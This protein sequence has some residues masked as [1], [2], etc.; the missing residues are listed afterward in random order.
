MKK[1]FLC[2]AALLTASL[3]SMAEARLFRSGKILSAKFMN[4][5]PGKFKNFGLEEPPKGAVYAAVMVELDNGRKIGIFDYSL[6]VDG[7]EY[8]C[9][10]IRDNSTGRFSELADGGSRRR[11]TL[12]FVLEASDADNAGQAFLVCK[13][14]GGG[15]NVELNFS[16]RQ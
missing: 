13:A 7:R 12:F 16:P 15:D 10:A 2:C 6:R 8:E 9:A 11:C 1:V 14:P 5:P 4:N 3:T